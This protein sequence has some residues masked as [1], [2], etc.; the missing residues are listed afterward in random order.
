[1][2]M[3]DRY[4][5]SNLFKSI[6]D[7]EIMMKNLIAIVAVSVALVG[8]GVPSE[9]NLV[10]IKGSD[11]MLQL[12]NAWAEAYMEANPGL[13]VTVSGGGSGTG[14]ASLIN[15]TTDICMASRDIKDQEREDA[16]AQGIEAEE[17]D[18]ALDGIAVVVNPEN[19]AESLSIAQLKSIFTGEVTNWK[20]I[21]EFDA[22][23]VL[24]SR[25]SSSGTF[26]FFSERVLDKEDYSEDAML[27]P[28]TTAIVDTTASSA[29]G[30]GYVGLGYV[31]ARADV[32][33]VVSIVDGGDPITPSVDSVKDGSYAIAR[34]LHFYV[35]SAGSNPNVQLFLDFCMSAAGQAIV[36]KQGYVPVN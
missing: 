24:L 7:T 19:P 18:V 36:A 10:S 14:I 9:E 23:I 8:C 22:E 12:T 30:I 3:I 29:G 5:L 17:H 1:M 25:E 15:G 4:D 28:S 32:I 34:P 33:K 20:D 27:L 31:E 35:N 16:S 6:G 2:L 11:T 26:A 13:I 21:N